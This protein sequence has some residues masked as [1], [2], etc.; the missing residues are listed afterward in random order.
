MEGRVSMTP[1]GPVTWSNARRDV[2]M[3]GD[4]TMCLMLHLEWEISV[5]YISTMTSYRQV[6]PQAE[7]GIKY[8]QQ[9]TENEI[10]RE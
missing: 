1:T 9:V 2:R 4:V 6:V 7:V 8:A 5:C 3:T 10:I